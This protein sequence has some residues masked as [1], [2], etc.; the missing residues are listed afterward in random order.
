MK[1]IVED[2]SESIEIKYTRLTL[3]DLILQINKIRETVPGHAIAYAWVDGY[4]DDEI[5]MNFNFKREETD[6]EYQARQKKEYWEKKRI[7][8]DEK[9]VY[10]QLKAKFE[11]EMK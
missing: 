9:E 2:E 11:G 3:D 7:E 6:E 5:H 10:R 1:K 4:D 8:D